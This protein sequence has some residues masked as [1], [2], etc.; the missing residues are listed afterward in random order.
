MRVRTG[1]VMA[2]LTAMVF[3]LHAEA[4]TKVLDGKKTKKIDVVSDV[5]R[6][7]ATTDPSNSQ[8]VGCKIKTQ[9]SRLDFVYKPA[10]GVAGDLTVLT[11]WFYPAATDVDLYLVSAGKVMASCIGQVSNERVIQMSHTKMKYGAKYTAVAFYS[12]SVGE[13]L[14]LEV[15]MPQVKIPEINN[16]DTYNH[17]YAKCQ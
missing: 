16:E 8:V 1:V 2:V 6:G 5:P 17:R 13:T 14:T 4:A 9:C 7:F 12:H 3:S 15:D 11:K 10:R